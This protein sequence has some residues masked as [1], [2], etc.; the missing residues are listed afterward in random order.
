MRPQLLLLRL[1]WLL[2]LLA[3]SNL[4]S[5]NPKLRFRYPSDP[6]VLVQPEFQKDFVREPRDYGL[7]SDPREARRSMGDRKMLCPVQLTALNEPLDTRYLENQ[8]DA[9]MS[10]YEWYVKDAPD[11]SYEEQLS[12]EHV[13]ST[14]QTFLKDKLTKK[15]VP[16]Q[17]FLR[18]GMLQYN[19]VN[20]FP[21]KYR[22]DVA[23]TDIVI[24]HQLNNFEVTSE[25]ME[26]LVL[27]GFK[28]VPPAQALGGNGYI[29]Q[30]TIR[31]KAKGSSSEEPLTAETL[32]TANHKAE[33]HPP[34]GETEKAFAKAT[35]QRMQ[36]L[37]E[38]RNR[39][40]RE[41]KADLDHFLNDLSDYYHTA[42]LWKPF[43]AVNNSILMGQV[44]VLLRHF[45]LNSMPH[46]FLDNF[47]RMTDYNV[48]R[49]L[50][51]DAFFRQNPTLSAK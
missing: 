39:E 43:I 46:E 33:Y 16:E 21:G 28:P 20:T 29:A 47:A 14:V 4:A 44:N 23:P 18:T 27:N 50:F 48:F 51:K 19:S 6:F 34:V 37:K 42:V 41:V 38:W 22:K 15:I 12:V 36:D 2:P 49:N 26:K 9:R 25:Q 3:L 24:G 30:T 45:G 7:S 40:S 17:T 13:K 35:A 8:R 1:R 32:L 31:V 11:N 5:A 10:F